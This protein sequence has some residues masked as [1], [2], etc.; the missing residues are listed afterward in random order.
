M[1]VTC[2]GVTIPKRTTIAR[3]VFAVPRRTTIRRKIGHAVVADRPRKT[4]T[5][6]RIGPASDDVAP[7]LEADP[8]GLLSA[9]GR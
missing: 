5:R 2:A 7:P 1:M 6:P 4:R 3:V 9:S 8:T